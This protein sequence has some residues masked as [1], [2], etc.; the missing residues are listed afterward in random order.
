[1]GGH[2]RSNWYIYYVW[3]LA[4]WRQSKF[5]F[6]QGDFLLIKSPY[7]TEDLGSTK[8]CGFVC[9]HPRCSHWG[10]RKW[11]YIGERGSH[12]SMIAFI[13]LLCAV[14]RPSVSRGQFSGPRLLPHF[15]IIIP[16]HSIDSFENFTL[17][18]MWKTFVGWWSSQIFSN[19][20][21]KEIW[22]I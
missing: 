20:V 11:L 9:S 7:S 3:P 22:K 21:F 14:G 16:I 17:F 1:M 2:W 8:K 18:Q 6:H 12:I 19:Q 15:G 4:I 5:S 13:F 10:E